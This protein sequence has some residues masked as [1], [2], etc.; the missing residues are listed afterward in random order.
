MASATDKPHSRFSRNLTFNQNLI[1]GFALFFT[2]GIYLAVLG[3]GAGGGKPSSQRVS[4]ISNSSLYGIYTVF[5][6]FA[7]GILNK[8]GPRITMTLGVA[9]YP[10]YVGSLF[11]Y[12]RTGNEWFPILGGVLL[13]LSAPL[14][15][16]VSGFI[17]WAY[18]TEA[19]KGKYI[20]IQYFVT[21]TG[22]VIGSVVAFVIIYLGTSTAEG[23]PTSIYITF[24]ILMALAFLFTIFGLVSPADV[25]RADG[26]AIA[27]FHT[28]SLRD[29]LK[30]VFGVLKDPRVLAMLPVI[31]SCELALGI[32]PSVNGRYFNLRTRAMNNILFYL[33]QLPASVGC[34]YLTDRLPYGRRIRGY[35]TLAVLSVFVFAGWI[36]LLVWVSVSPTWTSPPEGGVDWSHGDFAGPFVL[37]IVF[38]VIYG[39]HQLIGMW[40]MGTFTNKPTTLAIYGGLWKGVAA[41]GVAV[42][43]GM[44]A[45]AVAY[46]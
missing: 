29:E 3:L 25:R 13:G 41:G 42:Q 31:F 43:F 2:V 37:Y 9:G 14:L 36:A 10:I 12:D 34:A 28:L 8:F 45:A 24:I 7:G 6:F 17:Q 38:G 18:A 21:Q 16:S 22:S 40:V 4:D 19:E 5:G 35:I 44:A 39:S 32:L 15:W 11:Y 23:S 46:Q 27:V 20:A 33:V 30:G 26:T 1:S